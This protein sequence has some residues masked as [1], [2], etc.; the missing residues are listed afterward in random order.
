MTAD[1]NV[2][3]RP[4]S[5]TLIAPAW[6]TIVFIAI[7]VGISV[8]GG[9][10]QHAVKQHPQTVMSSGN[11]VRRYISVLVFEW[12][13]VLY[14]RM[15]V[16]KRGLRLRDLVGG[17]WATPTDVMKDVAL[18]AGLWVLWI[19]LMNPHILGG[20]TNAAQGLLPQ[21]AFES[22]A[23]IPLALSAGFCEELAFRGYLQKQFQAITGSAGWAV[24]I[25]AIV[26][27]VGHLYEGVG[28]V[29]RITLFGVLF[30]LL[31]VWRKSLRPGMIAHAWSDI[32]GVII[33]RGV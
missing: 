12:L 2:T 15:G 4:A 14:V 28:P 25:Q 16:H 31:A 9:F 27:G 23:W 22:L 29:G 17:R 33:F 26:F 19:G 20:G 7:F 3:S 21:G 11:A 32:F 13:L 6:H 30:G 24:F 5:R 1:A 18:G 8:V 10:F